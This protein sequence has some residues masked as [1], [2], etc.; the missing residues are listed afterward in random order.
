MKPKYLVPCWRGPAIGPFSEPY[1][2]CL[3]LST[4]FH[5]IR[6]CIILSYSCVIQMT[7]LL[8]IFQS[9]ICT[10][11]MRG[12]YKILVGNLIGKDH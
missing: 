6:F 1:E 7:S 12:A 4:Y 8:H 2:F 3:Q 10:L 5:M 11:D 9:Q